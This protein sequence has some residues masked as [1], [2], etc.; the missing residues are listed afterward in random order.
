MNEKEYKPLNVPI[1]A[2]SADNQI[3]F[4]RARK[5]SR[6]LRIIG[7]IVLVAYLLV[8]LAWAILPRAT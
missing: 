3:I 1:Y 6:R 4:M 2:P 8:C 7:A 5:Y